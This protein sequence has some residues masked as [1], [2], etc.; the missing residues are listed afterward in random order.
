LAIDGLRRYLE[1]VQ[2]NNCTAGASRRPD[3]KLR[4]VHRHSQTEITM[5]EYRPIDLQ[6]HRAHL[7][8]F[9]LFGGLISSGIFALWSGTTRL[10]SYVLSKLKA[11][12]ESPDQPTTLPPV[13]F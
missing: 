5:N 6:I 8:N 4:P 2:R 13:Y 3:R 11:R 12:I 9:A 10:V 1:V 7:E